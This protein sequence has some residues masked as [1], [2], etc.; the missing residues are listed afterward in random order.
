MGLA[1]LW[2][3]RDPTISLDIGPIDSII[4]CRAG[5]ALEVSDPAATMVS[6]MNSVFESLFARS[7]NLATNRLFELQR[8]GAIRQCL[9]PYLGQRDASLRFPPPD[10]VTEAE[11]SGY[12]T[13]FSAMSEL[14]IDRLSRRGEQLVTALIKEHWPSLAAE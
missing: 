2:P 13:N 11:V 3:G 1:P 9:L 5:Y 10:L 7:Q 14:W 6:R 8:S 4:A 12:P